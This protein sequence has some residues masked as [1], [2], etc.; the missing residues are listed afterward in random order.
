MTVQPVS[1]HVDESDGPS[2]R[3]DLSGFSI[4]PNALTHQQESL[5]HAA[6]GQFGH[7]GVQLHLARKD[8]PEYGLPHSA[9]T[10]RCDS[11][12][13]CMDEAREIGLDS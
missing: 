12:G 11:P 13:V 6:W 10:A 1:P 8:A 9:L 3:G 2:Q 5:T 4:R 7:F